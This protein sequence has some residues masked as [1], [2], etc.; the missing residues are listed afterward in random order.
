[1]LE[2]VVTMAITLIIFT[3]LSQVFASA[4]SSEVRTRN[5]FDAQTNGRVALD[6]LTRELHCASSVSI[7]NSSGQ[8]VSAGTAGAGMYL[9]LGGYCPTNGLTSSA[10]ATVYV[11]W[12]T[13]VSPSSSSAYALY[14]LASLSS[15]PSCANTG[16]KWADYVTGSTPFCLPSTTAACGGVYKDA[17]SLPTLHL[18]MSIDLNGSASPTAFRLVDDIALRNAV[19]S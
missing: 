9:N 6:K 11:T 7:V 4:T 13:L 14:R 16:M 5:S 8:T 18:D 1:M 19:R 12:C 2:L 15:Q 3:G 10:N 17:A